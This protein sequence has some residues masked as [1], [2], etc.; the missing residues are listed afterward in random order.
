MSLN[1]MSLIKQLWLAILFTVTLTSSGSFVL[2]TLS[3]KNYL[4]EQLQTKNI[5]NVTSLAL[6]MSQLKKDPVTLDLLLSAQFDSGH[7]RYIGLFDPNGKLISERVNANS[8]TKAPRWFVKLIPIKVQA[9]VANVQDGWTQYGSLALESDV[10]F[11]YDK[12]WDATLLIALWTFLIGLLACYAGGKILRKILSPLEEVV[13][14][15]KA[16]GEDRFITIDEPKTLEFKAVVREMN[17]LSNRIKATV[18]KESARLEELRYKIN[19]D[20]VTGLMNRDYFVNTMEA[21]LGHDEFNEGA[22]VIFRLSNLAQL[23]E[24]MGYPQA[25]ALLRK[26]SGALESECKKNTA[27]F[28]GRL[29]GT[30]FAIF[31]KKTTDEFALANQLKNAVT[32]A[33]EIDDVELTARFLVVTTKARKMDETASLFKVLEFIL[34]LSSLS[35]ENYLRVINASSIAVTESHYLVEWETWLNDALSNKRIKLEHYPVITTEG[36]LIHHESP[37]RLQL[38]PGGKW[39]SAGEFINWATQL[40][41]IKTIDELVL[42]TAILL[43]AQGASPMCLNVSANAM[44]DRKYIQKAVKLVKQHLQH[45]SFLSFEVPEIAA[46]EHLNE[47]KYFCCKLKA[48]GCHVGVEHVGLRISRL[49][50]LHDIGLDYIKFDASIVRSINSNETNKTLLRGLCMV[51]HSIGVRAI[52]EGVNN[53]DEIKSLKEIGIDGLTGPGVKFLQAN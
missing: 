27:L 48:V 35:E 41:L 43:L 33:A 42:E 17:N 1:N 14:Q 45:P 40:N 44:C 4:E 20:D 11:A 7:Y 50:E 15:A 53:D 5:D 6:S 25:N 16:I 18:T 36:T 26:I 39:H 51:A 30:E 28:S 31:C 37:V 22:L 8:Q 24:A 32:Q 47:F 34:N 13:N 12:L 9:G 29:S 3:S 23:D 49:G 38:E 19:Y 52:A 46:F 2:S 10:N 21:N